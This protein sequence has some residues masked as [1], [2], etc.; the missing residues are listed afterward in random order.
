MA[1]AHKKTENAAI[2]IKTEISDRLPAKHLELTRYIFNGYRTRLVGGCA[3][4][5]STADRSIRVVQEF[6]SF[7]GKAP[8]LCSE[9]DFE[10]WCYDMG[11]VR[12]CSKDTQR[13]YQIAIRDFYNYLL[14]KTLFSNLIRELSGVSVRQVSF[15]H[16]SIAHKF[17]NTG[18]AARDAMPVAE[19][20]NMLGAIDE[21]IFNAVKFKNK[22]LHPL[23]RDKVMF[24][25]VEDG[26]LRAAEALGID[27]CD[28]SDDPR[29]PEFGNFACVSVT[30]KGGKTRTIQIENPLL[31]PLLKMYFEKSRPKMMKPNNP[32]ETAF[33]LS[34]RGLR[35]GYGSFWSRF[36]N[37]LGLCNLDTT[38]KGKRLSPH[39]LRHSSITNGA[40][41]GRSVEATRLKSGH[42]FGAT[43]QVYSHVP[44][45]FIGSEINRSIKKTQ[46]RY[47]E[48]LQKQ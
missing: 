27:L 5:A 25:L 22:A 1:N 6:I 28:F 48:S 36:Q 42:A 35:L 14:E 41:N 20:N 9:D 44:D 31:P 18:R 7:S 19:F 30:G 47:E 13:I 33:F 12:Q 39:C 40:M 4:K 17:D 23:I 15:R 3:Q 16:N 11:V 29:V 10:A 24:F 45:S 21:A 26:G 8:W 2:T 34:E 43:G 38:P 46:K 32:N 37:A